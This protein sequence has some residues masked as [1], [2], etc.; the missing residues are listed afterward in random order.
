MSGEARLD[1][2]YPIGGLFTVLGLILAGFGIA[3]SGD[4]AMYERATAVNINLAWGLVML[5]FGVL[6]IVLAMRA[7]GR[8]SAPLPATE[9]P[10]GRAM[11]RREHERGLEKE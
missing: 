5:A 9:S 2:R 7:R 10:E 1:L 8:P 4:T 6:M 3:T 11:E